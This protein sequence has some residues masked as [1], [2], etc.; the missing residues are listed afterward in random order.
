MC[1]QLAFYMLRSIK[2]ACPQVAVSIK[3]HG[4]FLLLLVDVMQESLI[5]VDAFYDIMKWVPGDLE[6]SAP[7]C[8]KLRRLAQFLC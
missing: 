7:F 8:T 3:C 6:I 1:Q 5:E 2:N 4:Y